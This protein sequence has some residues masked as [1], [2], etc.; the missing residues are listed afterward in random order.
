MNQK[1]VKYYDLMCKSQRQELRKKDVVCN[2]DKKK[3]MKKVRKR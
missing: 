2:T 1:Y 3:I